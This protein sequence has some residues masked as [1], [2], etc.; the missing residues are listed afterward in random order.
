MAYTFFSEVYKSAPHQFLTPSWMP[1]PPLSKPDCTMQMSPVTDEELAQVIKRCKFF[2]SSLP[3]HRISYAILK[4]CPS[5]CP[6]L[7]D[8]YNRVIME[9]SVPSA[10]KEA[11][12]KLLPKSSAKE[13]PSSPGN[14]RSIA[15]TPAISKLPSGIL[16]DRWLRHMRLNGYLDSDLQKAFLLTVPGVAEYQA[17][18]AAVINSAHHNKRAL[19]VC[20][21]DIAKAYGSVHHSLIQFSLVHYHA[22]LSSA[23]CCI[24]GIRGFQ[25]PFPLRSD[26]PALSLSTSEC[27]RETLSVWSF[28]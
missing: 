5:L 4:R 19:A 1:S 26:P 27:I 2:S 22:P 3:F 24:P 20:W 25:P 13:N 14:F 17:K 8:L 18:L 16:K 7:L 10:W 28:S 23:D 11:A 15:L 12:V 21:L 6:A 9:G